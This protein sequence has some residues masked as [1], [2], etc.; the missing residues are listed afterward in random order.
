MGN[1]AIET[2]EMAE[3]LRLLREIEHANAMLQVAQQ[4]YQRYVGHLAAIHAVPGGYG[5]RDWNVGFEPT[6]ENTNG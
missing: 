5:M 3:G 6:G 2:A 1:I 4:D